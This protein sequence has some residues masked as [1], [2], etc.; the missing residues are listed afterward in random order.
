MHRVA[1]LCTGKFSSNKKMISTQRKWHLRTWRGLAILLP[2]AMA[3]AWLVIP[4]QGRQH[5]WQA[6]NAVALPRMVKAVE[7]ENYR[8]SIRS[9]NAAAVWQLE[10]QVRKSFAAPSSLIYRRSGNTTELIGRVEGAGTYYFSLPTD[11]AGKMP[12]V[13]LVVYDIIH[14]KAIDSVK[15]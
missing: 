8:V 4:P 10:W 5:K 11:S 1:S 12:S 6:G 14:A 9:N 15:L 13:Q 3:G 7:K 2:A